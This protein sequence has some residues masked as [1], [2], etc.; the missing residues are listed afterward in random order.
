M[1]TK[2][3]ALDD[4]KKEMKI[5]KPIRGEAVNFRF[6]ANDGKWRPLKDGCSILS[7]PRYDWRMGIVESDGVR[8][9]T[10]NMN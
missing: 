7:F 9:L 5:R 1:L 4:K 8:I 2:V 6:Q 10:F 3:A